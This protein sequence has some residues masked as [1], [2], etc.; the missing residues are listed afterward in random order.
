MMNGL[1]KYAFD[2]CAAV[3][4]IDGNEQNKNVWPHDL[5]D[6]EPLC[7]VITRIEFMAYPGMSTTEI[8][9]RAAFMQNCT[10]IPLDADVEKTATEIRRSKS[11]KLPDAITAATAIVEHAVLLT[12]DPHLLTLKW[13]GLR[14][15]NILAAG[16]QAGKDNPLEKTLQAAQPQ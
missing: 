15:F 7:S 1:L 10:V 2:N 14:T 4:F 5:T 11:V 9:K 8:D 13:P 12:S 6:S 16:Q 3:D